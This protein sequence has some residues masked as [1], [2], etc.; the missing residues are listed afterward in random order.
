MDT[1]LRAEVLNIS[2]VVSLNIANTT[3]PHI[4]WLFNWNYQM[5]ELSQEDLWDL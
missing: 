4:F 3:N 1:R 2:F 5:M